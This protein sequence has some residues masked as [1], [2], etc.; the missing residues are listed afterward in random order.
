MAAST[1]NTAPRNRRSYYMLSKFC[2]GQSLET[3]RMKGQGVLVQR[4]VRSGVQG[5][6]FRVEVSGVSA[7]VVRRH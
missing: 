7:E 3:H 2:F 1:F 5:V 6:G 4:E